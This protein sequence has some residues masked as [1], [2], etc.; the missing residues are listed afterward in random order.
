[1][2][3]YNKI[4]CYFIV[5]FRFDSDHPGMVFARVSPEYPEV[6]FQLFK[7]KDLTLPMEVPQPIKSPGMDAARKWYLYHKIRPFVADPWKDVMCPLPDVPQTS[8]ATDA[9]EEEAAMD[10]S[11]TVKKETPGQ[12]QGTSSMDRE[13]TVGMVLVTMENPEL[14]SSTSPNCASGPSV[15]GASKS[16]GR[17]RRGHVSSSVNVENSGERQAEGRGRGVEENCMRVTRCG[18]NVKPVVRLE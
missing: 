8:S 3:R 13:Q 4:K 17:G 5:H 12:G 6:S 16:R 7:S 15:P 18:R 2:C 14:G 1:M 9:P 11:T 10:E